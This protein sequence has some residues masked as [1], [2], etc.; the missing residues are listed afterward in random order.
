MPAASSGVGALA[1]MARTALRRLRD[2]NDV[3]AAVAVSV[4]LCFGELA[5]CSLIVWRVPYTEIDWRA[6]MDEVGGYLAGERD[7]T[8][9]RGD[10]GPLVYPAGFV[11]LYAALRRLTGGEVASAQIIFILVY[12][13]NLAAVLAVY[14]RARVVPPWA[15]VTLALSKRV[16]SIFVLR[17]FNDCFAALFA[18]IAVLLVQSRRWTLGAVALSLGVS[19]KMNVLLM[20]PPFLVLLVGGARVSQVIT[21]LAAAIAA[22]IALATP[23]LAAYPREYVARAFEFS[24]AFS[25]ERTVNWKFVPEDVFHLP[26]SREDSSSRT[27]SRCSPSRTGGGARKEADSSLVSSSTR[28]DA[29]RQTRRPR[30]HRRVARAGKGGHRAL[31]GQLRGRRLRA[32]AALSVLRVVFPLPSHAPVVGDEVSGGR[33]RQAG[34]HVRDRTRVVRVSGHARD[35]RHAPRRARRGVA[36]G[37]VRGRGRAV[38]RGG[39]GGGGGKEGAGRNASKLAEETRLVPPA[40]ETRRAPL[41]TKL[42]IARRVVMVSCTP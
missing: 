31:R 10:T 16:H 6:Y 12:V 19:V 30:A 22:Q 23:F 27:S 17:L 9:L 35:E 25:R 20:L 4:A 1:P 24:R 5:L 8:K 2:P 34:D 39:G 29:R 11:Y 36:R 21:A 37:V 42:H 18:H 33:R 7:Y 15:L 38:G 3:R 40:R 41:G 13:A 26:R 28:F 32:V 14:V